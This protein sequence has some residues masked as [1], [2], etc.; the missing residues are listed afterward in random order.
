MKALHFILK[1]SARLKNWK[2]SIGNSIESFVIEIN[3]VAQLLEIV[4]KKKAFYQKMG[5][6]LQ[7]FLAFCVVTKQYIVC[8]DEYFYTFET[9][10]VALDVLFKVFFVFELKYPIECTKFWQ[11][12]QTYFYNIPPCSDVDV[13]LL[14][15]DL[16]A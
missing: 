10:L 14:I 15:S 6:T 7:P 9:F 2:P 16:S 12:V 1:P 5:F 8:I 4:Q 3:T 11:F 13:K